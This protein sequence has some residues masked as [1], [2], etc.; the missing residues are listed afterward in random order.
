[1]KYRSTA[2]PQIKIQTS[3]SKLIILLALLLHILR[4]ILQFLILRSLIIEAEPH[5]TVAFKP[6]TK[7]HLQHALSAFQ[8]RAMRSNV[9]HFIPNWWRWRVSVCIKCVARRLYMLGCR[10][11]FF[12]MPSIT[13]RPPNI[14]HYDTKIHYSGCSV[15]AWIQKWSMPRLKSGI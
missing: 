9:V 12:S 10:E 3:T 11:R 7:C 14:Y 15:P 1:M 2:K 8:S 4:Q 13:P 6:R 5:C